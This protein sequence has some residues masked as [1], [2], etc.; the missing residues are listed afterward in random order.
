[1]NMKFKLR[2]NVPVT[3][4]KLHTEH[5]LS[6]FLLLRP[7]IKSH[8]IFYFFFGKSIIH[9]RRHDLP[10]FIAVQSKIP[11]YIYSYKHIL[12]DKE[13]SCFFVLFCFLN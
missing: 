9:E 13:T 6:F 3:D 10:N 11:I 2:G 4:F 12:Y 7:Q 1:M 5:L 8:L